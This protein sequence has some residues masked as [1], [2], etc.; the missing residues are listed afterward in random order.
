MKSVLVMAT[1]LL[2]ST[3]FAA[4]KYENL[5]AS[6]NTLKSANPERVEIFSIGKNNAGMDIQAL[7]ISSNAKVSDPNKIGMLAVG[8]HHGNEVGAVPIIMEFAKKVLAQYET[9]PSKVADYE[10]V[11]IPVLNIPGYNNN[12][13][14]ENG[15]DPNRDYPGPCKG[16]A[17][18]YRLKSTKALSDLFKTRTFSGAAV[19]HGYI[20][21][22][23]YPWGVGTHDPRT[24]D[25]SYFQEI[26]SKLAQITGYR[27]GTSTDIV[28][29]CEGAFE[30]WA[31]WAHGTWALLFE[32]KN[33]SVADRDRN[34]LALDRFFFDVK[35]SP[36]L[37]FSFEN[38]CD[39]RF[40]SLDRHD[41]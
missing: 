11:L 4:T 5:L 31:Y 2:S 37:D 6:M 18:N 7:R 40:L 25:H 34:V 9:E 38:G 12:S 21:T 17:P 39:A 3:V 19:I 23:T 36:S 24:K 8:A 26:T 1:F 28:Y 10:F 30:D 14:T 27:Y 13:R 16:T 35:Q 15:V 32:I 22:I 33:D 29:P 20:G 41:E